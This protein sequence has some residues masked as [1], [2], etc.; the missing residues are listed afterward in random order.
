MAR[1]EYDRQRRTAEAPFG[2]ALPRVRQ[3]HRLGRS[4]EAR[5]PICELRPQRILGVTGTL[6]HREF[7]VRQRR[8]TRGYCSIRDERRIIFTEFGVEDRERSLVDVEMME[9]TLQHVFVR[10]QAD[11]QHAERGVPLEI[12]T[13]RRFARD[14]TRERGVAID[15]RRAAQVEPTHVEL[16]RLRNDLHRPFAFVTNRRSQRRVS[17]D[18][19]GDTHLQ[20][21]FVESARQAH[22][23]RNVIGG[24]PRIGPIEEPEPGLRVRERKDAATARA[25]RTKGRRERDLVGSLSRIRRGGRRLDQ[26]V[27]PKTKTTSL[28]RWTRGRFGWGVPVPRPP[29]LSDRSIAVACVSGDVPCDLSNAG[30]RLPSFRDSERTRSLAVRRYRTVIES[31]LSD[32]SFWGF[33]ATSTVMPSVSDVPRGSMIVP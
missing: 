13:I 22:G 31:A 23:A 17:R 27:A 29:N 32:P 14:R 15:R 11:E 30:D 10:R 33:P 26:P 9:G 20:R 7:A 6:A 1:F 8:E 28:S 19:R 24:R 3:R 4:G 2:R 5:R 18:D 16:A 25:F 21:R 12:V